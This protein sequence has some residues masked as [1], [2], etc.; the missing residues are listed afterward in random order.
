MATSSQICGT[1]TQSLTEPVGT[2]VSW[3]QPQNINADNGTTSA[4]FS[5]LTS[6]VTA[7]RFLKAA[8]FSHSIP[9]G[10]TINGIELE[11]D[12]TIAGINVRPYEIRLSGV[13]SGLSDNLADI[14]NWLSNQTKTY[15]DSTETW[16]NSWTVSEIEADTFTAYISATG[17]AP[18]NFFSTNIDYVKTIV[19]YT[20]SGGGGGD[21]GPDFN[22][23]IG[24]Q[25][26]SRIMMG[27][28]PVGRN[29][30]GSQDT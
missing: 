3:N 18:S 4:P 22:I 24:E 2:T 25:S 7:T 23:K 6:A 15:G 5:V 12:I 9:A 13:T 11:L 30:F 8:E 28:Q 16:G 19:H 20:E 14:T 21:D 29:F 26:I 27:S 10:S 17:T 1:G